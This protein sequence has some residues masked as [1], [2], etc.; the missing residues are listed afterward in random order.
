LGVDNDEAS[1]PSKL[2]TQ[3][4]HP[5]NVEEAAQI[6]AGWMREN[7]YT[8][9]LTPDELDSAYLD[10]CRQTGFYPVD[11]R[12]L[13]DAVRALEGVFYGRHRIAAPRWHRL[14][15]RVHTERTV[16]YRILGYDEFETRG[17]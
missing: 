6:F 2:D 5:K 10:H 8:D 7:G 17:G 14:R 9:Y 15:Q 3:R 12:K 11:A 1:D 4:I 13:R 16:L